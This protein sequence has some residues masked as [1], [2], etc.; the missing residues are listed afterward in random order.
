MKR[1][2]DGSLDL[3]VDDRVGLVTDFDGLTITTSGEMASVVDGARFRGGILG[4]IDR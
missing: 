1:I 2:H 3:R 4:R